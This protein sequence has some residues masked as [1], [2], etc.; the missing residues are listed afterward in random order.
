MKKWMTLLAFLMLGHGGLSDA[1]AQTQKMSLRDLQA[2]LKQVQQDIVAA[3]E[4]SKVQK[5]DCVEARLKGALREL[6]QLPTQYQTEKDF[7]QYFWDVY[8]RLG[9]FSDAKRTFDSVSPDLQEEWLEQYNKLVS[10]YGTIEIATDEKVL[11]DPTLAVAEVRLTPLPGTA[12]DCPYAFANKRA[13]ETIR[14]AF[15]N[16]EFVTEPI[17]LPV[18]KHHLLVALTRESG[19]N[20]DKPT[21]EMDINVTADAVQKVDI[22]PERS[23][24]PWKLLGAAG[25]LLLGPFFLVN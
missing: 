12:T 5:C 21:V 24:L 19:L 20:Y 17:P 9:M 3:M 22:N 23:G 11:V 18:G 13:A 15:Q 4:C 10:D 8:T 2:I 14:A 25:A 1:A 16:R 7:A 6:R